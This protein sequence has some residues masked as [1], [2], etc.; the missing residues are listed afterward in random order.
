VCGQ[1]AAVMANGPSPHALLDGLSRCD[2]PVA[3]AWV[4]SGQNPNGSGGACLHPAL[5]D[6]EVLSVEPYVSI[7]KG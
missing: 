2:R 7:R 3:I 1:G 6:L 4:R 5:A